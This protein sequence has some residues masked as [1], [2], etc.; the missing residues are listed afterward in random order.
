[1]SKTAREV[2]DDLDGAALANLTPRGVQRFMEY[3]E[4][5]LRKG[6]GVNDIDDILRGFIWDESESEGG[7]S[8]Q[9]Y[10]EHH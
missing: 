3:K 1:M 2:A 5:L 6:T 8:A 9:D 7:D 10:D 4:Q